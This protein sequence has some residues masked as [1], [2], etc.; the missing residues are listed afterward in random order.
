MSSERPRPSV[1]VTGAAGYIGGL[2]VRALAE[3]RPE[4]SA[5][6]ALDVREPPVATRLE[7]VRY[8]NMSVCDDGL[9][10]VFAEHRIDIVVHLASILKPPLKGGEDL[11]YRV[12]VEGTRNVLR[13]AVAEGVEKL[14]VTTSGAAYG[15]HADNPAWLAEEHPIRGNPEIPY[16]HHKRL[17]EDELSSYRERHP[18]L[19]QLVFRPGTV[20][21]SGVSTPVTALFEGKVVLGVLGSESPFVFIWDADVVECIVRG[22]FGA[23][24]GTYNLAG[25][26]ALTAREIAKRLG[27]PYLPL[28]ARFIGAA[29]RILKR[30]GKSPYGPEQVKFLRY[31]P[32]LF[33]RALKERFGYTPRKTS[34]EAFEL[35]A[36]A[37]QDGSKRR[38]KL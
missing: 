14:I 23:Q 30:F 21:G 25:D 20:I 35:Y 10:Q 32:V 7:G 13:A 27:K 16:S 24:T 19:R 31:R 33:N 8:V 6:V 38:S 5:L 28:P 9:S 22:V 29:L 36:T 26:G 18:A 1:L 37:W 4:L 15:Y 17:I 11:A 3:R 34:R 12:D 2:V